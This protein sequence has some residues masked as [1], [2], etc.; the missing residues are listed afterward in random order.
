VETILRKLAHHYNVHYFDLLSFFYHEI[1]FYGEH[2]QLKE[3]FRKLY[4]AD[5]LVYAQLLLLNSQQDL[6]RFQLLQILFPKEKEFVTHYHQWLK[7]AAQEQDFLEGKSGTEFTQLKWQFILS[8][9]IEMPR[10]SF[11]KRHFVYQVLARLAAHYNLKIES[12]IDYFN[13][14]SASY[15]G[16][17]GM[18]MQKILKSLY[19]KY[20]S[21]LQTNINSNVSEDLMQKK[22]DQNKISMEHPIMTNNAGLA[23][24]S[25]LLPHFFNLADLLSPKW[26]FKDC[27]A[28]MRALYLIQYLVYGHTNFPEYAMSL[29]KLL[30]GFNIIQPISFCFQISEK[31]KNLVESLLLHIIA[32]WEKIK[33]SSIQGLRESFLQREGRLEV[34]E[35][36]YHLTVANRSYDMLLDYFPWQ[37]H[38]IKYPWMSKEIIV[39]WRN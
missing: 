39:R 6:E 20:I 10:K 15:T 18:E 19:L 7:R 5:C 21:L 13:R 8:V 23:I 11:N 16:I 1:H 4:Y 35:N 30:I 25:P 24:L 34:S 32:Q 33:N 38:S 26:Q 22:I 9:L 29:N 31:E 2:G 27:H 37:I 12:L 36:A 28:Q 14:N 17:F 3:I